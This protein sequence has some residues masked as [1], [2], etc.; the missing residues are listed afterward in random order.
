[1]SLVCSFLTGKALDWATA[2]WS[3]QGPRLTSFNKFI[4][5]LQEVL[6]PEGEKNQLLS[7]TGKTLTFRTYAAQMVWADDM[8]KLWFRKGLN[9]EVQSE[10][11][12]REEGRT[13]SIHSDC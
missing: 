5:Q 13:L 10:L 3:N 11:T 9:K 7:Q 4:Q 2:V 12:C 1:M 8:L 6:N